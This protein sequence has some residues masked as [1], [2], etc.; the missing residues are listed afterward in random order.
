M[1]EDL[2]KK[3]KNEIVKYSEDNVTGIIVSSENKM[4][5]KIIKS[6]N[7]LC[8]SVF[9]EKSPKIKDVVFQDF[10]VYSNHFFRKISTE[11]MGISQPPNIMILAISQKIYEKYPQLRLAEIEK[12]I[13]MGCMGE[14]LDDEKK[15]IKCYNNINGFWVFSC[16]N[17]YQKI[18]TEE[19]SKLRIAEA[20][21]YREEAREEYEFAKDE[22]WERLKKKVIPT[23]VYRQRKC[24]QFKEIIDKRQQKFY[25][26]NI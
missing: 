26:K 5:S 11:I 13:E 9:N 20:A 3:T 19:I 8:F 15:V 7:D 2:V 22:T 1:S 10:L 12:S 24:K 23:E 18:K 25:D 21:A 14:L 4:L 16:I 17:S 6:K